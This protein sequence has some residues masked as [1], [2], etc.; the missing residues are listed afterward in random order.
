MRRGD[1]T[2]SVDLRR[3]GLAL[4]AVLLMVVL[5]A[6]SG[7]SGEQGEQGP[8]GEQGEQGAAGESA[9]MADLKPPSGSSRSLSMKSSV[10]RP[11]RTS[12]GSWRS[13]PNSISSSASRA[14]S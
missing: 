9:S 12:S 11:V 4:M 13:L 7:E 10:A 3:V 1:R 5:A 2:F 14:L 6:C 8:Q